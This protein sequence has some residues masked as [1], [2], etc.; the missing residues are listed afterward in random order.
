MCRE[1]KDAGMPDVKVRLQDSNIKEL[2]IKVSKRP[3]WWLSYGDFDGTPQRIEE[4]DLF[5]ALVVLRGSFEE[6]GC[7]LLCAG[8]RRDAW[9]SS[10]S[11]DMG[12][13]RK[14]NIVTIGKHATLDT[15]VDI[16]DYAE[17]EL[18]GTVDEQRA[19]IRKWLDSLGHQR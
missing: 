15:L 17:P 2:S 7:R 13:G 19:Y 11:R 8:A 16:F 9:A 12:G 10:M 5:G 1:N 18:V 4:L 3:P 14:V 6:R